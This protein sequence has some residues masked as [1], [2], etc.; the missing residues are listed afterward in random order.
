[1]TIPIFALVI[2]V[3]NYLSKD[4]ISLPAAKSDALNLARLLIEQGIPETNIYLLDSPYITNQQFSSCLEKI[5]LLTTS[6]Q[7]LFYFCG[8]GYRSEGQ[9]PQSYLIFSDSTL[10][11]GLCSRGVQLEKLLQGFCKM[12]TTSIYVFIDACHLRLNT[13]INPKMIEEIQGKTDSNKML[14]CLFSSGILPSYE[15][16]QYKYGYFTEALIKALRDIVNT[17]LSPEALYR[18][19]QKE[20]KKNNLPQPEMYNIGMHSLDIF[21]K[22]PTGKRTEKE[23]EKAMGAIYSCGIVIDEALFCLVFDIKMKI[24]KEL[25]YLGLIF[26]EKGSWHPHEKLNEIVEKE[27]LK[28]QPDLT[29]SYWL[30]QYNE[31]FH[32]HFE[33]AIHFVMSIQ[34]FGYDSIFDEPLQSAF[35][36]LYQHS[37]QSL[38]VLKKSVEIYKNGF[39]SKSGLYL[40]E[41]LIE[42]QHFDLSK[43]LLNKETNFTS[44]TY[45]HLLWRTGLFSECIHKATTSINTLSNAQSKI[46]YLWHRGT[47]YYL[48]GDWNKAQSDFSFI[49]CYSNNSLDVGRSLCL[50]GTLTGMRGL[51]IKESKAKIEKGIKIVIKSGDINGAWVGWNNLGEIIGK[52][53]DFVLSELYLKKALDIA[54]EAK[55]NSMILETLRNFVQLELRKPSPSTSIIQILVEEIEQL[56]AKPIEVFECMQIYNTL[57]S[58]YFM[59]EKPKT[60]QL[61][62]KKAI[63]WTALSKEYHIYTLSNLAHMC[64]RYKLKEK[65][66]AYLHQAL[67]LA[68]SGNN[69]FALQQLQQLHASIYS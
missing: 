67:A 60:A 50:L 2:G 42:L 59:M 3:S 62:L 12:K 37:S 21:P 32:G 44:A 49:E 4:F 9:T 55:N 68:Q 11:Q 15:S 52:A 18:S 7:L 19:I 47:S 66:N 69:L 5:A 24:F 41:I 51:Q 22:K 35:K 20:L 63:P 46:S 57:C 45:C 61:F 38:E 1:M 34:C 54:M 13:V 25:E 26:Y 65:S 17:N 14:F 58:A 53:G 43:T 29:K 56:L 10:N 27:R 6:F 39:E 30:Q 28:L 40:A 16:V 8:H 23:L 33:A 48:T 31:L 64:K 36:V